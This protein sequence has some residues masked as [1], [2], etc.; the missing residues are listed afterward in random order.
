M[1]NYNHQKVEKKWQKK[2]QEADLFKIDR[3]SDKEK[4]YILN[5][6]PYPSGTGLHMGHTEEASM[7]DTLYRFYKMKGKNVLHPYG[8]DSFGLPAENYAIKT[9]IHPKES[10]ETAINV[11][12]KQLQNLG[13][14][15][16]F[17]GN[18][19]TSDPSY[20]R[21]TQFLFGKFF[22]NDLVYKKTDKINWCNSCNTGIA[23]EQVVAGE[24]E[25]CGTEIE[26]KEIPGYFFK[27]TDFAEE[28][29]D[30]LDKVDWP[31]YTVKNQ[32]NWIGKSE[33]AK[34][35]FHTKF[36]GQY[37][38]N[39]IEVFTTRPD[40]LFG[41]T[42]M[43]LAP[44]HELVQEFL[45][46]DYIKNSDEV[47][48]YLN[49]TKRKT[50][51]ERLEGKEKTGVLLD[52]VLATNPATEKS[53]MNENIDIPI[54][55][56]DYVL[57]GYGTGAI[58][59]VPA[60]DERDFEFA[61]KFGIDV[62]EVI[63]GDE[64][65]LSGSIHKKNDSV[66]KNTAN[67]N[68]NV[69][70]EIINNIYSGNGILINSSEFN[71]MTSEE[72]KNKITEFVGGELTSNYRLRDWSISRQRYWGTPIPIVY[73]PEGEA[74]FVGE[75]NLPWLLPTDVDID[76]T[77]ESPL[78]KS[79]EFKERTER[80]FG[81]G[82]T[83]EF[84]T[85]DTFVDSSWYFLRYPDPENDSEFASKEMLKKWMPVDLYVG[86][87]EHTYM[88]LLYARFFVKAMK[89]IGLVDFNEPFH[90]LKH[91][92]MILDK[93]GKKMSKSKGNVVNP[94][95]MVERFGAD[96]TRS[97]MLFSSPFE[98][99]V[100]WNEDNIVGVYRFLEKVIR[101]SEKLSDSENIKIKKELHKTIKSVTWKTEASKFN[102]AI[103]DM[104]KFVNLL[105]KE[106]EVNKNDYLEL[107]K[108]LSVYAP[109]VADELYLEITGDEFLIEK[110]WPEFDDELTKDDLITLAVQVNGKKRGEIEISP[111]ALESEVVELVKL[112]EDISKWLKDGIKKVIYVPGRILNFVVKKIDKI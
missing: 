111:E 26:Q 74:K 7:T 77:G 22:E 1:K 66:I 82:W 13:M 4:F 20:Y 57:S 43:V 12:K 41:A 110:Q 79:K 16:N 28:L 38:K 42:Y 100:V 99:D 102:T 67:T 33:G 19:I 8:F 109:H 90:T 2:W 29:I 5:M 61:T 85:M 11:F 53:G 60:H 72:A 10:T 40:T 51:L 105:D 35:K 34:I 21:W 37:L 50:E 89:K 91:Q 14:G 86:G 17:D 58:M 59:A 95:E 46:N 96:A 94:D 104:M 3:K 27:I 83:P 73:S 9:G 45:K 36:Q 24:C 108:I 80:I 55:I 92:G 71:G 70:K 30:Y 112:N 54:Y 44:E 107:I 23:N 84:D 25:R 88:H 62:K 97:Y 103:S 49:E 76:P 6:F 78:T 39:E 75:E 18:V 65:N 68:I 56:S 47:R 101:Q 93:N 15:Y 48:N 32:R 63:S 64:S 52:G 81:E 87:D 98:D 69:V 31:E 106:D